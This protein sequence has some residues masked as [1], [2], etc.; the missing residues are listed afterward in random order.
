MNETIKLD[1]I[2]KSLKR[3]GAIVLTLDFLL[4]LLSASFGQVLDG[5]FI[6]ALFA[7]DSNTL[8]TVFFFTL[9]IGIPLML[10]KIL[11]FVYSLRYINWG[12]NN[13]V[14][15]K[16]FYLPGIL[17]LASMAIPY[18]ITQ[19]NIYYIESLALAYIV[20]FIVAHS[21]SECTHHP[22]KI[23]KSNPIKRL[24]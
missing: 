18:L 13:K 24:D 15:E 11:L 10:P 12:L 2:R 14:P 9:L 21:P 4:K 22:K 17:I 6:M 16:K 19:F 1:N 7:P 8:G 3:Y 20:A 23:R 5:V